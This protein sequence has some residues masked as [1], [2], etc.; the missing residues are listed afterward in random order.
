M[1]SN[2]F[3]I[4]VKSFHF[5]MLENAGAQGNQDI[6][7]SVRDVVPEGEA[8]KETKQGNFFEINVPFDIT[9]PGEAFHVSGTISRY[10]QV[11]DFHGHA[12]ELP[13][14]ELEKFSR[15]LVEYVETLTY[16]VTSVALNRGVQLNF[17][18]QSTDD[19]S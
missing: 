2:K 4:T 3:P 16:S 15:P 12:S 8:E 11:I 6:Q 7:I 13:P 17:H 1:K 18:A 5:D 10:L 9:P 19:D 14:E